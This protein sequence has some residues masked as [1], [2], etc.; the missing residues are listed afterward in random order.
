MNHPLFE[1]VTTTAGA[2]S[3]RNKQLNE[4]M[5]NPV[6]PWAEANALYIEQSRLASR[7]K[8]NTQEEL[9]L[10]DV[11]L[12][13]AAN[14]LA[15]LHCARAAG[16]DARPL[17]L[18]SFERELELLRYTL[19]H[20]D[21]FDRFTGFTEV[22]TELLEKGRWSS[23]RIAWELRHGDFL[24][25]VKTEVYRP[26]LIYFD[27]YSSKVNREMWSV[28]CFKRLRALSRDE[29]EGGTMLYT[30]SQATPV[31]VAILAGGFFVG[32]GLASGPK[33]E[34]TIASSVLKDLEHPLGAAWFAR[35]QRSHVKTPY[36]AK[37]EEAA[38]LCAW[39]V[40]HPQ[41]KT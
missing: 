4:I 9:V 6:G 21:K 10:F 18:V 3:I 23:G 35:W 33:E 32:H 2:V 1:V 16:P 14:A 40:E 30:Y 37:P 20:A 8:E 36:E 7:L 26:H 39:V 17:R 28:S 31:R 25:A 38:A 29:A 24:D 22:I 12:G 34:T 13:A 27:P 19:L 41:F 11:G 5:H 15:A